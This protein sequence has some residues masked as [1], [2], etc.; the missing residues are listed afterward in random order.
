VTLPGTLAAMLRRLSRDAAGT[1]EPAVS[2]DVVA[3]ALIGA[4]RR[5]RWVTLRDAGAVNILDVASTAISN[6]LLTIL[7]ARSSSAREFG[8]FGLVY[9]AYLFARSMQR[10]VAGNVLVIERPGQAWRSWVAASG[11]TAFATG[12]LF[13]AGATAICVVGDA[14]PAAYVVAAAMPL[15][16]V[17]E[18]TRQVALTAR[19]PLVLLL[20][21]GGWLAVQAV[22]TVAL[23][24]LGY[25]DQP[26]LFA[27]VWAAAAVPGVIVTWRRLRCGNVFA[28]SVTRW[29]RTHA[30][31]VRAL[32]ADSTATMG[33]QQVAVLALGAL[34]SATYVAA[35]R[36]GQTLLGP[37]GVVQAALLEN[38]T[39]HIASVG[40]PGRGR[41]VGATLGLTITTCALGGVLA[42]V[43]DTVGREIMG[44][45][46]RPIQ[47]VLAPLW[48]AVFFVSVATGA[49]AIVRGSGRLR[50]GARISVVTGVATLPAYAFAAVT[51]LLAETF[52]VLAILNAGAA[53]W[54]WWEAR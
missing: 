27:A 1:D 9:F 23:L 20:N 5:R 7:V 6:Y 2:R 42:L 15:L 53:A 35:V 32:V 21:D 17:Q 51:G 28:G 50:T 45:S 3:V 16:T 30:P 39:A 29:L 11:R 47:E 19:R 10:A 25:E 8:L 49:Q 37:I 38:T 12:V 44:A 43:P 36:G 18:F 34:G 4:S 46:W 48:L 22:A 54:W 40:R 52:W 26:G 41:A 13:A 31:A 33:T 14:P 24:L